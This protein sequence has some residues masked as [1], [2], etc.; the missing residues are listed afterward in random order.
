[1]II[2]L[3]KYLLYNNNNKI[4]SRSIAGS[5]EHVQQHSPHF[6]V[7]VE[8]AGQVKWVLVVVLSTEQTPKRR[9]STRTRRRRRTKRVY[10]EGALIRAA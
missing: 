4:K 10:Q 8:K 3:D 9:R 2:K 7:A 5:F 6:K 1:M